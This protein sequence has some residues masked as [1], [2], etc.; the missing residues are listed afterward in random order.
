VQSQLQA[1]ESR[2]NDKRTHHIDRPWRR[3]EISGRGG[4]ITCIG[5]AGAFL[6]E[7]REVLSISRG[8]CAKLSQSHRPRPGPSSWGSLERPPYT[9]H[10]LEQSQQPTRRQDLGKHLSICLPDPQLF[11]SVS[12][13]RL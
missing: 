11:G 13:S 10:R 2:K 4:I 8:K 12:L 1:V 9:T 5:A 7:L 6:L 3:V